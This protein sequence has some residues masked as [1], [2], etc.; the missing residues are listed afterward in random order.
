MDDKIILWDCLKDQKHM[1][2]N[3]SVMSTEVA[4]SQLL[5]DVMQIWHDDIQANFDIFTVMNQK[6]FYPLEY[7]QAQEINK[8]KTSAQSMKSTL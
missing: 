2:A 6:G 5:S 8:V 7:A 4:C 1:A 3:Y